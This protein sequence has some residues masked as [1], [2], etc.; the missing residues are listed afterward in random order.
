MK[1]PNAQMDKGGGGSTRG[2]GIFFLQK[3]TAKP[4]KKRGKKE[5]NKG[6]KKGSRGAPIKGA[7]PHENISL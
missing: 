2:R 7:D 5:E 6:T 4:M 1:R 3:R